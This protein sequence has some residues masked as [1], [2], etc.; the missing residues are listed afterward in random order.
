[1]RLEPG[2]AG[3]GASARWSQQQ[4]GFHQQG[5]VKAH[6][7][8]VRPGGAKEHLQGQDGACCWSSQLSIQITLTLPVNVSW[9]AK[10]WVWVPGLG[11]PCVNSLR[12]HSLLTE[13]G[14]ELT[15]SQGDLLS[16]R[17]WEVFLVV[18]ERLD[19]FTLKP[20]DNYFP[21]S[22]FHLSAHPLIHPVKHLTIHSFGSCL[23]STHYVHIISLGGSSPDAIGHSQSY[24]FTLC[25]IENFYLSGR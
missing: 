25:I 12:T 18:M 22:S 23:L 11:L 20:S 6:G 1:M 3:F 21:S 13:L 16:L 4:C 7:Q 15:Y 19:E 14:W 8:N 10:E 24:D 17:T 2:F 9:D 5:L